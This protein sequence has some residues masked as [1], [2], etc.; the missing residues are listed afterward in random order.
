MTVVPGQVKMDV[1]ATRE[2]LFATAN[3]E[4][5]KPAYATREPI[6][7]GVKPERAPRYVHV[8]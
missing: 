1:H 7:V 4:Q 2:R 6:F 8:F 3:R 5:G